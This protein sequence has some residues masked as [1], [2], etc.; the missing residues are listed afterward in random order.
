MFRHTRP[1]LLG[2]ALASTLP[3]GIERKG[4]TAIEN[5]PP[6]PTGRREIKR[7]VRPFEIKEVDDAAGTFTGLAAA[8][9]LD[10]GGDVII[11]GAFKRTLADWRRSKG[12][13]IPLIDSH[14][15]GSAI[16]SIGTMTDAKEVE[17]GLEA[18]FQFLADD[19]HAEA[20]RKRVKAGIV[21]GLSIGYE[22]VEAKSPSDEDRRKGVYRYLKE[23]KLLEVSVVA[24]PMNP[25]ARIDAGSV[26]S[27]LASLRADGLRDADREEL[28]QLQD[29][30]SALLGDTAPGDPPPAPVTE[31]LAIDDPRRLAMEAIYRDVQLRTLGL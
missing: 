20:I 2:V 27:F 5:S 17:D 26:K 18:T 24:F 7:I 14:D 12:K 29:E 23:I 30:I 6:A 4:A 28:K 16:S 25:D 3:L 19:P 22:T 31:G 10:Y 21:S 11:P 15:Y 8:Y 9:S 13:K 1:S